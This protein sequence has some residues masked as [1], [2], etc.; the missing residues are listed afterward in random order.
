MINLWYESKTATNLCIMYFKSK[1]SGGSGL[2][3]QQLVYS[4]LLK[5]LSQWLCQKA[6]FYGA[7]FNF[8]VRLF[9]VRLIFPMNVIG[10]LRLKTRKRF[11]M[12]AKFFCKNHLELS[13]FLFN[14]PCT[15]GKEEE[16][17]EFTIDTP[18]N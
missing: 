14:C 7:I 12:A 10:N 16:K 17:I 8:F 4:Y 1:C 3:N 13:T 15:I 18:T 5:N 9:P 6:I 11:K 2:C